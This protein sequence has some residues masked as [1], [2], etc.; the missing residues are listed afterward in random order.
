M[1]YDDELNTSVDLLLL[2]SP[3][4]TEKDVIIDTSSD[5][6]EGDSDW[7][8]EFNTTS[9]FNKMSTDDIDL[10]F[11]MTSTT[12]QNPLAFS[13]AFVYYSFGATG[14]LIWLH[15]AFERSVIISY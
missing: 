3:N 11:S 1:F 12:T 9:V 13:P 6:S 5:D 2:F 7:L 15:L 14:F 10:P 4:G 8:E